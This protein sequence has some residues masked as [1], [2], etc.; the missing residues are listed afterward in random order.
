MIR[1]ACG[2]QE[3]VL[4]PDRAR[5]T[6]SPISPASD[7]ML[8]MCAYARTPTL[9]SLRMLMEDEAKNQRQA[10]S[11]LR[12]RSMPQQGCQNVVQELHV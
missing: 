8:R 1:A 11:G 3:A 4:T 5:P 10:T 7:C 6:D 2:S 9:M 12:A